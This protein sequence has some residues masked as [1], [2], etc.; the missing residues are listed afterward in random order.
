MQGRV[1]PGDWRIQLDG[2]SVAP[3]S[4]YFHSSENASFSIGAIN[5]SIFSIGD[6][7]ITSEKFKKKIKRSSFVLSIITT[8]KAGGTF[9]KCLQPDTLQVYL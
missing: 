3:P 2:S 7:S 1:L 4:K 6:N 9:M 8:W 5:G